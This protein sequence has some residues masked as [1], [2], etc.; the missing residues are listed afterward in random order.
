VDGQP[1]DGV[2]PLT[3]AL[4]PAQ[5][6]RVRVALAGH[7]TKEVLVAAGQAPA[8]LRVPLEPAGPLGKVS[9]V[10]SYPVDV[11]WKGRVLA[12]EQTTAQLSLPAGKQ[13]VTLAAPAYLLRANVTVDVPAGGEA[14]LAA[15]ALGRINVRANPD[16]CKVYIDGTF[17]DYPPILDR[18]VAKGAHTVSFQWPDGQRREETVEVGA[19]PAYVM[20][21]RE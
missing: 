3:L 16:N 20:G 19:G 9:L 15:P 4:D 7:T 2:T 1:V 5:D 10:S 17:I 14:V 8:E 21:R 18:P 11:V 6:H 13:T 12:R